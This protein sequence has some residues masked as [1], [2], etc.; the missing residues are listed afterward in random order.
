MHHKPAS[1]HLKKGGETPSPSGDGVVG[2][3]KDRR[4]ADG[5]LSRSPAVAIVWKNAARWPVEYVSDN[6]KTLFGW[7]KDDFLTNRIYYQQMVHPDDLPRVTEE[8]R[9]Y[10]ADKAAGRVVHAPYRIVARDGSVKWVEDL[11][12]IL[13][14]GDGDVAAYEGI[15]LDITDRKEVEEKLHLIRLSVDRA[16]EGISWV[17]KEGRF[18]LMNETECRRLGYT[19]EELA[20]LHVYDIDEN[21]TEESW[22]DA[23]EE[24]RTSG[25]RTFETFH[26]TKD[27][28]IIPI[29]VS[30]NFIEHNGK[31]YSFT[32]TRDIS[33]RKLA[34]RDRMVN[35]KYFESMDRVN[36]AVQGGAHDLDRIMADVLEICLTVFECDRASLL[37]PCDP[38][39]P[40]WSIPFE[41][42][43]P[44]CQGRRPPGKSIPMDSDA[45]RIFRINLSSRG[46][47]SFSPASASP[48]SK[49]FWEKFGFRSQI[50][51]ALH[52]KVGKPWQFG[53]HQCSH[54]RIW[55]DED[56]TL[57]EKIAQRLSDSLTSLLMYRDLRKSEEFLS[58]IVENIPDMILVKDADE[59]KFLSINQ[60]G[61]KLLGFSKEELVGKNSYD[62][63][64]ED[65]AR[66]YDQSDREALDK[67]VPVDIPEE[68]IR[69]KKGESRVLHTKKI[70]ILDEKGKPQHLLV[71]AEDITNLKKLQTQ[72]NQAQKM[73]ALGTM[74]GGIAHDFNNILQPMLGYCEFLKEDLP[75]D[76]PLHAHVDGVFM[77][78]MRAKDLVNQILAFSRQSERQAIPVELQ[79]VVKEAVKLC[80]S[81]IS[82]RID[83]D[84]DLQ[85][86]SVP[87]LADPTQVHQI[88]M[89]LMVNAYHAMEETGG[90]ISIRLKKIRLGE[91]DLKGG[92]LQPGRY[93]RLSISDT[94]CGMTPEIIEKIFEPYFTTKP[95]GKGTG[96]GLAVAY[97]IIREH[98]GHINVYSEEGKGA[99][100]NIYLPITEKDS[101]K[102]PNQKAE[103][104]LATG[105]EHI[106]LVDDEEVVLQLGSQML[107]R[108]GYRI[109]TCGNGDEALAVFSENPEAF[110]LVITDMNMPGMAGDRLA[111]EMIALRPDI[112]IIIC[113]GFSEL[114]SGDDAKAIGVKE[115][116]MKPVAI[117][118]MSQA[119]RRILDGG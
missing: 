30:V 25:A 90:K 99:T 21:M 26:R 104:A 58:N 23:W 84:L 55:T 3:E 10:S 95:Q 72:L 29:E 119:V 100:F 54:A 6:V 92:A 46:A 114:I 113:T 69:N 105:H 59:L 80:R 62:L 66:Q 51:I 75:A 27:G 63:S 52:P 111:R 71:I 101:G 19:M 50:V 61:E 40:F 31:E 67:G 102:L 38:E 41:R 9:R 2:C 43:R 116:L 108:I 64:P 56:K 106:L 44:E 35:L 86:D 70:P 4:Y 20:D 107:K 15:L 77:A 24:G 88:I 13:R 79:L 74:S 47:V 110:D 8:V 1:E 7:N 12:T 94:G 22:P 16:A 42:T 57:F 103:L 39:A 115:F 81:I 93:A 118:E 76:S 82:S 65:K 83:I 117:S 37:Y 78:A 32:F 48:P 89:N 53:L 97:G 68:T 60:A 73:E 98:G 18:L 11:T 96:L 34:E 28:R 112:P 33:E 17:S 91:E 36:Q 14:D 5:I 109:T 85:T 87:I 49:D 45:A